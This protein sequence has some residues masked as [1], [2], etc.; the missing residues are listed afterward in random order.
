M[1]KFIKLS[2]EDIKKI[3]SN[4]HD[5]YTRMF[6]EVNNTFDILSEEDPK[7]DM[8]IEVYDRI[9]KDRFIVRICHY[10]K[11]GIIPATNFV[12]NSKTSKWVNLDSVETVSCKIKD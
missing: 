4:E 10:N 9:N 7:I 2:C 12:L 5:S 1:S 6:T 8:S 3:V 11:D